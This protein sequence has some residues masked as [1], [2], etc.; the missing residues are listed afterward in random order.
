[1]IFRVTNARGNACIIVRLEM[2]AIGDTLELEVCVRC[3]S[4]T[5]TYAYTHAVHGAGP[6]E[7]AKICMLMCG[8]DQV[9]RCERLSDGRQQFLAAPSAV[10]LA[11]G[12]KSKHSMTSREK[13]SLNRKIDCIVRYL[14]RAQ[15]A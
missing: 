5:T 6:S 2:H 15:D 7:L 3:G 12:W 14:E 10:L 4:W 9:D 13:L 1:M 11:L 8:N